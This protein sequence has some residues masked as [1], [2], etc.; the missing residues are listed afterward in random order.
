MGLQHLLSPG[1]IP[2]QPPWWESGS[3]WAPQPCPF[4]WKIPTYHRPSWQSSRLHLRATEDHVLCQRPLY[5]VPSLPCTPKHRAQPSV[6]VTEA[7]L[8]RPNTL[9]ITRPQVSPM[10]AMDVPDAHNGECPQ[11]LPPHLR[12]ASMHLGG[13][14]YPLQHG[15]ANFHWLLSEWVSW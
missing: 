4:S 10:L 5:L 9:L 13:N 12:S 14:P 8:F 2:G 3:F 7:P 15:T 1:W 6:G 11:I